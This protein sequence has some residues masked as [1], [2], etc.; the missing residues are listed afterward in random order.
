VPHESAVVRIHEN[1]GVTVV[2]GA[3]PQ[4]QGHV[5]MFSRLVGNLL[6]SS[7]IP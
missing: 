7:P 1:G 3:A 6:A 5:T 4:G 2:T